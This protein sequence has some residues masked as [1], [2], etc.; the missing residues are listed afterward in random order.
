MARSNRVD[1]DIKTLT[2]RL[3]AEPSDESSM[4]AYYELLETRQDTP[5]ELVDL[6]RGTT[7]MYAAGPALIVGICRAA[8]AGESLPRRARKL[9]GKKP[10]VAPEWDPWDLSIDWVGLPQTLAAFRA[11]APERRLEILERLLGEQTTYALAWLFLHS[12]PEDSGLRETALEML[13]ASKWPSPS[14]AM[15]VALFAPAELE[16]VRPA[17]AELPAEHKGHRMV[18][19]GIVGSLARAARRGESWEPG[20]DADLDPQAL[21]PDSDYLFSKCALPTLRAAVAG[22]P[23]ERASAWSDAAPADRRSL[24][25]DAE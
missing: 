3:E 25:V 7:N 18:L 8:E 14:I 13:E 6:H 12:V 24:V 17:L 20:L 15:G 23:P 11:F 9:F 22:L 10:H 19:L 1:L 2:K 16:W 5:D 4:E 21:W